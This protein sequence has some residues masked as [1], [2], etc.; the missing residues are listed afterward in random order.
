MMKK[1]TVVSPRK[2]LPDERKSICHKFSVAEHKGYIHVGLYDDGKP[3][4]I[5]IKMAKEG[6]MISGLMDSFAVVTSLALQYGTPLEVIT[7]KLRN[8]YFEPF[9]ATGSKDIPRASSIMDYLAKWLAAK[10][11]A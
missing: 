2:R 3:G 1:S 6:S 9:G 4:E 8:T 10:F 5:F 7:S 11:P